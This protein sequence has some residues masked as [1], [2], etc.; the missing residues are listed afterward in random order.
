MNADH[1][2]FVAISPLI[3]RVIRP[4]DATP[5]KIG[6]PLHSSVVPNLADSFKKQTKPNC[7]LSFSLMTV[8]FTIPV[9]QSSTAMPA[10]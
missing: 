8:T 7:G 10:T 2:E 9:F 3:D 5:L 6:G 4:I 1:K